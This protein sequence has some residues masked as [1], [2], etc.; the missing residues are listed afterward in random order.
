MRQIR[1]RKVNLRVPASRMPRLDMQIN[2]MTYFHLQQ[3]IRKYGRVI[4][5]TPFII[6]RHKYGCGK[7][8]QKTEIQIVFPSQSSLN[9]NLLM[10]YYVG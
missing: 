8:R 10:C 9:V 4:V 3:S 7:A 5:T 1:C 6:V 2:G